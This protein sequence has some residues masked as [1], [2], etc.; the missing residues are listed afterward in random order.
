MKVNTK[1]KFFETLRQSMIALAFNIFG[2]VAGAI[3][4][5][6]LGLF[7]QVSWAIAVFPP[8]LSAR[9]VIAGSFCGRL[10]TGLHLGTVEPRF[11]GN[12]K[13]FYLLFQAIIVLTL[14][15]SIT[16]SLVA[17]L[18]G[19]FF[20]GI[21]VSD[22]FSIL[23]VVLATMGLS[24]VTISPIT[25]IISFLSFKHG[26]DPDIT[27]YPVGS[28]IS[29]L[30]ITTIYILVVNLFLFGSGGQY[31]IVFLGLLLL[32]VAAYFLRKNVRKLEFAKTVRESLLVLV[33]VAFI[34]NVT[35]STLG[36]IAQSEGERREIFTVYPALISIMGAIGSVV[37]STATTKLALGTL[38]SSLSSIRNHAMEISGVWIA[39]LIM[40]FTNSILSL[41]IQGLFTLPNF[42]RFTALLLSVNLVAASFIIIISYS[43]AVLTYQKG[44]DPDNFVIPIESSL[45]DSITTISML[46]SLSI[47]G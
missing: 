45:A 41:V 24:L 29:D 10:S 23:G 31:L 4:A 46:F 30:L 1:Q 28:T 47:I 17:I 33:F 35:G 6:Q 20:L 44:L 2:I 11:F 5:Y 18:F 14:E 8:V 36:K 19:S 21:P 43:V 32:F 16:M 3:V 13:S 34:A 40:F 22:F 9:G 27:L 7:R 38:K 15:A 37:G 26:L 25:M 12:T 42:L 39:S